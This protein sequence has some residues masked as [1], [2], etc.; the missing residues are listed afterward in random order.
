M[1]GERGRISTVGALA[2]SR[3]PAA[4]ARPIRS[5]PAGPACAQAIR[6]LPLG[7]AS[8][9]CPPQPVPSGLRRLASARACSGPRSLAPSNSH[10]SGGVQQSGVRGFV[11]SIPIPSRSTAPDHS[12]PFDG[13][14]DLVRA[15]GSFEHRATLGTGQAPVPPKDA[16]PV[17]QRSGICRGRGGKC[18]RTGARSAPGPARI[19]P[20]S[21]RA[22]TTD[23]YKEPLPPRQ[24]IRFTVA[25]S[26]GERGQ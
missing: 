15:S 9:A 20:N 8:G 24:L 26:A 11:P 5:L 12:P 1:L 23:G 19:L 16:R 25:R 22:T 13:S 10:V 6:S 21:S 7:A 14:C 17:P 3:Q 18:P 4:R 2:A